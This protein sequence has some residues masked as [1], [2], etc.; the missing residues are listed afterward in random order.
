VE[1]DHGLEVGA[2]ARQ[3]EGERPAEAV[4]DGRQPV[5]V[6]TGLGAQQVEPGSADGPR[7]QRIGGQLPQP[8]HHLPA[9]LDWAPVALVVEGEGH[10]AQLVGQPD[11]P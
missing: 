9:V 4:P 11:R 3:L 6:G 8:R 10:V 5:R 2:A 1:A 7:P